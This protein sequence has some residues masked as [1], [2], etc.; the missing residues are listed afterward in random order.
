M[1]GRCL[2]T[3]RVQPTPEG[4]RNRSATLQTPPS[5]AVSTVG[6][7]AVATGARSGN[8]GNTGEGKGAGGI[9]K[10]GVSIISPSLAHFELLDTRVYGIAVAFQQYPRHTRFHNIFKSRVFKL[11][12]LFF[13]N[14]NIK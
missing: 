14:L 9:K 13:L 3:Q 4:A 8:R 11:I 12:F 7:R 1:A 2:A 10:D 6:K 5:A